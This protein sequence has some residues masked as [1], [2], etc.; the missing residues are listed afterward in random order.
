MSTMGHLG[1]SRP[2]GIG[3]YTMVVRRILWIQN[4]EIQVVENWTLFG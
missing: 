4:L 3:I 1:A 2:A